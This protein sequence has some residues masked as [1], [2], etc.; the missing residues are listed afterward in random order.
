ML[1]QNPASCACAVVILKI[2][3]A[4]THFIGV[5]GVCRKLKGVAPLEAMAFFVSERFASASDGIQQ[6][7]QI[8]IIG[9]IPTI[10]ML[11]LFIL[12]PIFACC[13]CVGER[14][15]CLHKRVIGIAQHIFC[16]LET[17]GS[18]F[19][20][21]EYKALI[22]YTYYLLFVFCIICLHTSSRSGTMPSTTVTTMLWKD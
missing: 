9:L 6:A 10:S 18:H 2:L 8:I 1:Q 4:H 3:L 20:V 11:L 12:A 15:A 16:F 22:C 19:I 5:A 13:C 17:K 14:C 21:Y 7:F